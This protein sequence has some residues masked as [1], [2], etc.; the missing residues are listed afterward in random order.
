MGPLA[1]AG[2]VAEALD[3]GDVILVAVPYKA[4]PDLAKEYGPKFAGKIVIDPANAVARRDGEE[5]LAE[6]KEK[7]IGNTTRILSEGLACGARVQL[8][9]LHE[10]RLAGASQRRADG[11]PDGGRRRARGRGGFA[12]GARR[13]LRSGRGAACSARRSSR[14]AGRSTA[15]S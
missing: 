15:S 11:D 4:I 13:G 9:E 1:K 5:L 2:T 10:L 12:I 7:G 14:R 6:T 8:D 3:F